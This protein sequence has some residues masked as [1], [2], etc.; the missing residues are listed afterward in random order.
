MLYPVLY[1]LLTDSCGFYGVCHFIK[2]ANESDEYWVSRQVQGAR[3]AVA[4]IRWLLQKALTNEMPDL[5]P[6]F[7]DSKVGAGNGESTGG[8]AGEKRSGGDGDASA[9]KGKKK[10]GGG[11]GGGEGQSTGGQVAG[12]T[13][14]DLWGNGNSP[15]VEEREEIETNWSVFYGH[16]LQ[17]QTGPA[18]QF[19]GDCLETGTV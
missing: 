10:K 2:P 15:T 11:P 6:W 9:N 3:N 13:M 1:S 8:K 7:Q 16:Q 12:L 14:E 17:R 19:S 4:M 18:F 5:K